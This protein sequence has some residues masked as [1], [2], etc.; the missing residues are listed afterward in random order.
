MVILVQYMYFAYSN[1]VDHFILA[2]VIIY[3]TLNVI[4]TVPVYYS[5]LYRVVFYYI[6][7]AERLSFT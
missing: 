1:N 6:C 7:Y 4:I 3:C 2:C 5:L